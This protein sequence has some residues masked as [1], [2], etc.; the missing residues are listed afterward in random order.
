EETRISDAPFASSRGG[1]EEPRRSDTAL[2][3]L[4]ALSPGLVDR[5]NVPIRE[6]SEETQMA[7]TPSESLR[8]PWPRGHPGFADQFPDGP[9]GPDWECIGGRWSIRAGVA[10]QESTDGLAEARCLTGAPCFV[11]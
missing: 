8:A 7:D 4:R 2:E 9:L 3:S 5:S 1:R 11:A 10:L 6:G